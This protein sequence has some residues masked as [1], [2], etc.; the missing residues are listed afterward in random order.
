MNPWAPLLLLVIHIFSIFFSDPVDCEY[1][2][3]LRRVSAPCFE[4]PD[5]YQIYYSIYF[6]YVR[7]HSRTHARVV[8]Y[9][10]V[11]TCVV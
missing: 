2:A 1:C 4:R 6:V 5:P 7:T 3:A 8:G 10:V 9:A 11:L